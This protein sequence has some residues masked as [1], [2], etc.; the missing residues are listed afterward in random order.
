MGTHCPR[1]SRWVSWVLSGF[2][3]LFRRLQPSSV[4][5]GTSDF[6][7]HFQSPPDLKETKWK[8]LWNPLVR[9]QQKHCVCMCVQTCLYINT[10]TPVCKS[11]NNSIWPPAIVS[12]GIFPSDDDEDHSFSFLKLNVIC[13]LNF[14]CDCKLVTKNKQKKNQKAKTPK[15]TPNHCFMSLKTVLITDMKTHQDNFL[16]RRTCIFFLRVSLP[17]SPFLLPFFSFF[18][19]GN[20]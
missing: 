8:C 18:L 17:L 11:R 20:A 5:H 7:S 3:F 12:E 10:K 6:L 4:S 16:D 15:W 1:L 9:E 19:M 2:S 13:L 14:H